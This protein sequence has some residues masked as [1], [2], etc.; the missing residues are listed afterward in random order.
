MNCVLGRCEGCAGG[1]FPLLCCS[2]TSNSACGVQSGNYCRTSTDCCSG[3]CA[4][5]LD[6]G[7]GRCGELF[8]GC[9]P[10]D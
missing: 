2:A 10:I 3:C 4:G 6:G 1:C 5:P 9:L 8:A 7:Y